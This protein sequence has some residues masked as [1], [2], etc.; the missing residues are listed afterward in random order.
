MICVYIMIHV[1]QRFILASAPAS[2]P[3]RVATSGVV[4]VFS[5]IESHVSIFQLQRAKNFLPVLGGPHPSEWMLWIYLCA[6]LKLIVLSLFF[7]YLVGLDVSFSLGSF[8]C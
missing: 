1:V 6:L 7:A 5:C 2:A 8:L 3:A 4:V